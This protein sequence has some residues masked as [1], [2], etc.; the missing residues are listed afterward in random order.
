MPPPFA[1]V[2]RQWLLQRRVLRWGVSTWRALRQH[3]ATARV[4]VVAVTGVAP[5]RVG[6]AAAA[7]CG[8]ARRRGGCCAGAH[9]EGGCCSGGVALACVDTVGVAAAG[10]VVAR[11][12]AAGVAVA[13]VAR[14]SV[15][16][17]H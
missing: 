2:S 4:E 16:V 3:M 6:V 12:D 11:V 9:G 1:W 10:V 14:A 7:D 13:H 8:G 17:A 15:A 5:A